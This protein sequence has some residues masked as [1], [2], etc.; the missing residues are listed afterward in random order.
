MSSTLDELAK[1]RQAV[2]RAISALRLTP[3]MF[4][5]GARPHPPQ[6]LYRAYLAQSDIF[7]GLYWQRY[8]W[9][10]PGMD[11]SG[12][13]DELGLA[14]G[15]PRLL[16]VKSP[17]P[18]REPRLDELIEGLM[19]EAADS[20]RVFRTSTEL[21]RLV[22]DDLATLLS[23][24][25]TVAR[26]HLGTAPPAVAQPSRTVAATAP[27]PPTPVTPAPPDAR[28]APAPVA[29]DPP[30]PQP[31]SGLG[32]TTDPKAL[33][34]PGPRALPADTTTLVG[35]ESAIDEVAGL[36]GSRGVRLVTLTGPGGIGKTRLALAVGERLRGGFDAGTAFVALADVNRPEAA[37]AGI[38]RAIG[39]GPGF[40]PLEILADR[41]GDGRWLLILDN[42]EQ[43]LD[44]GPFLDELLARC[45][46]V[47]ILSTSRRVLRLRAEWEYPVPALALPEDPADASMDELAASP[48]VA[49]FVDRARAVRHDFVLTGD[50]AAAV[51]EICRRLEGLPLAIELAAA[52]TRLREPGVVLERLAGSLDALGAGP[53]DLPDRQR[54]LR[55]TVEWSVSM[56]DEAERSLL[57]ALAVFAGGWTVEAAAAVAGLDEDRALELTEALHQHSLVHLDRTEFGARSR[58]LETVREFVAERL[59]DRPDGA[60]IHRRHA[61]H[62]RRLAEQAEESL[63]GAGQRAA[64]NRLQCDAGNLVAA[65]RWYLV[66]DP[67]PVPHLLSGLWL[68]WTLWDHVDEVRPGIEQLLPSTAALDLQSRVELLWTAA[69][70]ADYVGDEAAAVRAYRQLE[71]L[72][73]RVQDPRLRALSY[74]AMAW[75]APLVGGDGDGDGVLREALASLEQLRG[76]EEPFWTALMLTAAA[77]VER[78][79]GRCDDAVRHLDEAC[80]LARLIDNAWLAAWARREL[81]THAIARHR[82]G[83]ARALLH[84]GMTLSLRVHD[85]RSVTLCLGGFARLAYAEGDHERAAL[86]AGA[87][88][89]LRQRSGIQLWSMQRS[90]RTEGLDELRAALGDDRFDRAYAAGGRLSKREAVAAADADADA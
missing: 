9:I 86:L 69:V 24:Q 4:E 11:V 82:L 27:P 56:L 77:T 49:L 16:Y 45:P 74:V 41:L 75:T 90:A 88:C 51:V 28:S 57:D 14:R 23:E 44:L 46:G 85:M 59:A 1:E 54:T 60:E 83:D 13:Q 52:R 30:A 66:N 81:S 31:P 20:F 29:L 48:A 76:L 87:A 65:M 80:E 70:L 63:R 55:T 37:L 21:G 36:L 19:E 22:R 73:D 10:G 72:R 2:A 25:F 3:V 71:P 58:M 89:A 7:I 39:V 35:R 12:L 68:F 26:P 38:C 34:A 17:A 84:E 53:A 43:V 79:L 42:L 32:A 64:G 18:D 62:Y 67:E 50:N 8:G 78:T 33:P 47:A 40:S 15:M 6:E 61:E 5:L